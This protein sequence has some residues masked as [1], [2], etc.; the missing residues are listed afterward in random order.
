MQTKPDFQQVQ[1]QF[2]QAIRQAD[3]AQ[4]LQLQPERLQLYRELLLNNITSFI[5][6]VYPIAKSLLPESLWRQLI[7][8]FFAQEQCQSPFYNEISLQF[9]DYLSRE[10]PAVLEQYPWLAELLQYEWLELYL[11]TV[12]LSDSALENS[13]QW[14]LTTQIWVLVYQYPVYQWQLGIEC[15]PQPSAIMAWRDVQDQIQVDVLH[16]VMAILIEQLSQGP[17]STEQLTQVLEQYFSQWNAE[18]YGQQLDEL[19]V[20]LQQQNLLKTSL[21]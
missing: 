15:Q 12:E 17:Q 3:P 16:P 1:H 5:D 11:D 10:Q 9:R 6:N 14:Q 2:C 18:Q 13:E 8:D 21:F 20:Y 7:H 4:L 19:A